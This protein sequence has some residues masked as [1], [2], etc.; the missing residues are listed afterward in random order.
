MIV[1][2]EAVKKILEEVKPAKL[3]AATKYVDVKEIEKL[4]KLGV[5]CF[6]ENRVQA[7]LEKYENYHGNGEFQFIGTLQPNKVKYIIDK[8]TLIHA[9]DRYSLLKEIEKQAAKR[10]LEMPVLIQVNIA[11]EE[12]KHGFEVEEIDEV[13]SNLKDYP[14]VKVR[15]LMMMAPHI[16]SSETEKYFKMTQELLQ[17]LQKE[18]PMYQLD[19]L[20][21]GMSNDYHEALNHGSTMIRI[22]SALFK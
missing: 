12:S 6:G 17:R 2:E 15:G 8:V 11:K 19:Q 1:N 18:Y 20:S 14:H 9:V 7:F 22:G 21:M 13:F 3:V 16:E 5:T 10:D 4:E